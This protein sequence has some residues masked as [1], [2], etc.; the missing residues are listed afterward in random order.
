MLGLALLAGPGSAE[1][2]DLAAFLERGLSHLA[3]HLLPDLYPP[4]AESPVALPPALVGAARED[5]G[6]VTKGLDPESEQAVA[7]A[8]LALPLRQRL[9]RVAVASS[10]DKLMALV[11]LQASE[12]GTPQCRI[13]DIQKD[14][15]SALRVAFNLPLRLSQVDLWSVDP[16]AKRA[17]KLQQAVFSVSADREPLL[18]AL[19]GPKAAKDVLG[20][21][22]LVRFSPSF[23]RTAGAGTVQEAASDLP[24]TAYSVAPLSDHWPQLQT[25]AGSDPR[26]RQA[27]TARVVTRIPVSD[28][29][30]AITVD[31]G[32]HPLITS[33]FLDT[34]RRYQV[35]VTFFVV[36]EKVEEY[37]ELLRR[38]AEEGHELGNHTYSHPRLSQVSAVEALTQVRACGEVVGR[39]CGQPMRLLRPPGGGITP[40]VLKVATAANCT[41]VLWTHNTNDWL[42]PSAEEIALNALR[43]IG[44]GDIILM[45]QGEL[46][47]AKALPLIIEGLR[48]KGLRPTTVGEMLRQA[49]PAA[50]PITEL[51][52]RT[53]KQPV[54]EEYPPTP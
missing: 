12:P 43:D 16:G 8:L 49:P 13:T 37:P 54:R 27:T 51:M 14:A 41:V 10:E 23:L 45:H 18:R 47:S 35:K 17:D 38:M 1:V 25:A 44:P 11:K 6:E 50:L 36:G 3:P 24:S 48:Q 15:V 19:R 39:V 40:G 46:Q 28:N 22:G 31:D 52:A 2:P 21:L 32:P 5:I 20:D 33:V 4:A 26:L 9:L 29:S 7:A 34:L 30:V 42:K 53:Q